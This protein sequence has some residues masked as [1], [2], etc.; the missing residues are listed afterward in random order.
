MG[1]AVFPHCCLS[2]DQ[3][4]VEVRKK[5]VTSFKRSQ[6]CSATLSAADPGAGHRRPTPKP[7]TPGHSQASLGQSLV[8]SLLL[9]PESWCTQGFVCALQEFV[10]PVLCKYWWFY[11]GINGDFLQE[12]LCHIQVCCTQRP[13]P[14]GRTLLTH[15]S[16]GD[17]WTQ[18]WLRLYGVSGSW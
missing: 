16:A 5:M 10:S 17:T 12:G 9:S 18:V 3:T 4:M 6:A 14:C 8:K 2:W 15:T 11:G 1:G 7:E 13:H